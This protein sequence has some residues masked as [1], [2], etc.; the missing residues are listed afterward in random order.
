MKGPDAMLTRRSLLLAPL[1]FAAAPAAAE[2]VLGDDGLYRQNW[3]LQSFLELGPDLEEAAAEGKRLA[4]MIE[5]RGCPYCRET[6]LVN[7]AD[8]AVAGYIRERF[9]VLQLNLVGDL[10]VTDFDGEALS[11]KRFAA[12][13]GVRFTPTILFFPDSADGL[14]DLPPREREVARLVGYQ[15]PDAFR[16]TFAFVH[17]RAYESESLT[18]YLARTA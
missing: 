1:A 10:E 15:E 16:R 6:H 12:R 5:Q 9:A 3:F 18:D 7:L 14:G 4:V 17:E 2:A 13:Y 11:E 8:P